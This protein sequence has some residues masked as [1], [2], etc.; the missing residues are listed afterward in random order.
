MEDGQQP[1]AARQSMFL[2]DP[3]QGL[4]GKE[5]GLARRPDSELGLGTQ[6]LSVVLE[7]VYDYDTVMSKTNHY[8]AGDARTSSGM[9]RV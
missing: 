4:A 6:G 3:L 5:W 1:T 2:G 8:Y 7:V 9:A